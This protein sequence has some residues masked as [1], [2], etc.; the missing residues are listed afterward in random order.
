[1]PEGPTCQELEKRIQE[2]E[3]EITSQEGVKKYH[4]LFM[5]S[6]ISL[7]E[8][9]FS[10]VKRRIDEIKQEY[11]GDLGVFFL[12]RPDLVR[13]L[14][15]LVRVIDVNQ[16]T[17]KLYKAKS[18][19]TL[20]DGI[21]TTFSEQ[22]YRDFIISL[23]TIAEDRTELFTEKTGLTIDGEPIIVQIHWS[24]APGYEKTYGRVL[25]CIID[26]TSQKRA[27]TALRDSENFLNS[28]IESVQDG[29]SIL[30]P[31]LTIRHTNGVMKRWYKEKLPLAG[32]RCYQAYHNR[33][34][35]CPSCPTLRCMQTGRVECEEVPGLPG[36]EVLWIE[37]FSYPMKNPETGE[38]SGVIEFVRDITSRRQME[39]DRKKL[40]LQHHQSQKAESLL[41]MARAIAHQFNN[42]LSVIMGNIDLVQK[43][44]DLDV[45]TLKMLDNCINAARQ[46][47]DISHLMLTYIGQTARRKENLDLAKTCRDSLVRVS[48]DFPETVVLKIDL[49]DNGPMIHADDAQIKRVISN[50]L[51]NAADAIANGPGEISITLEEVAAKDIRTHHLLYP[52]DGKIAAE[53]CACLSISD[54]GCGIPL[55]NMEKILDPFFS[56][57]V[58]SRGLGLSVV[59]GI[60]TAHGG[61]LSVESRQERGTTF[62]IFLPVARQKAAVRK[63][64]DLQASGKT[65][66]LVLV[67][68]DE[69]ALRNLAKAIL[70]RCGYAVIMACD[71]DE[72]VALFEKRRDDIGCVLLDLTMPRMNGWKTLSALRKLRPDIPVILYS[73]YDEAGVMEEEHEQLPQLFLQKPY[74]VADLKA[75]MES[76]FPI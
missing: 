19:K 45:N 32:K 42:L 43:N 58:P 4:Q 33:D 13:E 41:R 53:T 1:M 39:K 48:D 67:V 8:E 7:W 63:V 26:I 37:L 61:A 68:D 36:S 10:Q 11:A 28:V 59:L 15:G 18:K 9:D 16:A 38:I 30:N 34:A 64:P 62:R 2:L 40:Q 46:G 49:P 27:E 25:V 14:A 69:P 12:E 31:D 57:K 71:G 60:I 5:N 54:T 44:Q 70:E 29:I 51:T 55:E 73:G 24:V 72:A 17:L 3:K 47:A 75:A 74:R 21:T 66:G 56:T 76:V 6:P 20:L 65:R 23:T 52:A 22:S 50:L 35:A